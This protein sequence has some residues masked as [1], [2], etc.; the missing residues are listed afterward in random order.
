MGQRSRLQGSVAGCTKLDGTPVRQ[1]R[2][3]LMRFVRRFC[4]VLALALIGGSLTGRAEEKSFTAS[5]PDA[6]QQAA[7]LNRLSSEQITTLN[8]LVKRELILARQGNVRAFAAEFSQRRS[9]PERAK[10]GIDK[11]TPAERTQLD[12]EVAQAIAHQS[13]SLPLTTLSPAR[14]DAVVQAAG[15]RLQVHGSVS[16]VAGTSGGGRNFY[17]G[18]FEIEQY[19]PVHHIGIAFSYSELRGKGLYWPY[20]YGYGYGRGIGCLRTGY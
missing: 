5:L 3:T 12:A 11:L 7:G 4:L 17:G 10:A 6:Q 13:P 20:G 9:A 15:P 16:F 2:L 18:S 1:Q 19:D 14:S 8:N